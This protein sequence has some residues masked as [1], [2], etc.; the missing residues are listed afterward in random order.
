MRDIVVWACVVLGA[1]SILTQLAGYLIMVIRSGKPPV[2]TEVPT[3]WG[4]LLDIVKGL[5][6]K[7]PL[8]VG[9]IVL[10]LIAA[11]FSGVLDASVK[12]GS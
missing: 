4:S 1:A 11:V 7:A 2:R 6:D 5:S 3:L 8:L 10:L 12:L 9:G